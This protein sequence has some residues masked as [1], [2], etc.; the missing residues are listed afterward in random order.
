MPVLA[1]VAGVLGLGPA[2][3]APGAAPAP[4]R[5]LLTATHHSA[6][7]H[8]TTGTRQALRLPGADVEAYLFVNPRCAPGNG[9]A[10]PRAGVVASAE[11]TLDWVLTGTGVRKKGTVKVKK[12]DRDV[13]VSLPKVRT[14]V[15]FTNPAGKTPSPRS[16]GRAT[17]KDAP[18]ASECRH[19]PALPG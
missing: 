12:A 14:G 7:A 16:L 13:S 15:T 8:A 5:Q 4:V 19:A 17:A 10:R 11:V 6:G 1:L 9:K 2:S 18:G 3:A